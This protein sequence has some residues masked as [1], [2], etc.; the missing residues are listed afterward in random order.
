MV[1]IRLI[2]KIL[3]VLQTNPVNHISYSQPTN[4]YFVNFCELHESKSFKN[5]NISF[6]YKYLLFNKSKSRNSCEIIDFIFSI[7]GCSWKCWFC[8]R[9]IFFQSSK[10][11]QG[12]NM[13]VK[14]LWNE[15]FSEW[16]NIIR[17]IMFVSREY[18]VCDAI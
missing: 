6:C 15:R 18:I 1:P 9:V 14:R 13:S 4:P 16:Y 17:Y 11:I 12:P 8:K 7:L 10:Y 2:L 3:V 5:R